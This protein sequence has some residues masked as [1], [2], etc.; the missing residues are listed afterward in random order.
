MKEANLKNEID[1]KLAALVAR[2]KSKSIDNHNI[3]F[4]KLWPS[5]LSP[6]TT[7][8]FTSVGGNYASILKVDRTYNG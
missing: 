4:N 7:C 3:D 1:K 2:K 6:N 5:T 8:E